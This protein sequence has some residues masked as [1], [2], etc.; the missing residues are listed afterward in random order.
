MVVKGAGARS[1][2]RA[3]EEPGVTASPPR[4]RLR[5]VARAAG[6]SAQTV[7]NVLNG[8]TGFSEVTRV[9]VLAAAE[10]LHFQPNRAAQRLRGRRS[11]QLGTHLAEDVLGLHGNFTVGFLRA[12]IRAAEE[13]DHQL[14]VL[15]APFEERLVRSRLLQAGVDGFVLYNIDPRDAR[16]GLLSEAGIPFAV[17]GR[18]APTARQAWVDIDN[19]AAMHA[20]VDHLLD[21]GHRRFGYVGYDER[22]YWN[23]ER[24]E[25]VRGRLRARGLDLVDDWV[26][27]GTYERVRDSLSQRLA[28]PDRPEALICGSDSLAVVVCVVAGRLGLTLGRDLAVTGFDG[29]AEGLGLEPSLTTVM[30]PVAEGASRLVA[31]VVDQIEGGD[32]PER[33]LILPTRLRVGGTT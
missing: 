19:A 9:R 27:T 14:V 3:H 2:D 22:E 5:D 33:G 31:M 32:P 24:L 12:L 29:L 23:Y 17:L 26:I 16:P 4:P 15:T 21:R 11:M 7:S 13:E 30:L 25:G 10:R 28:A 20:V 1:D 18:T 6:V 8:R